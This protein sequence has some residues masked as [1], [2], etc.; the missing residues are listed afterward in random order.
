M[1]RSTIFLLGAL[2][3]AALPSIAAGAS[4]NDSAT[5]SGRVAD[6]FGASSDFSFEA[7]SG[8]AGEEAKGNLNFRNTQGYTENNGTAKVTCLLVSG[9]D[10]IMVGSW[11]GDDPDAWPFG[12]TF[13]YAVL[14][15]EDNGQP[16]GDTADRGIAFGVTAGTC[17]DWLAFANASALPLEQGNVVVRDAA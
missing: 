11:K 10:A 8:P 1:T 16:S 3:L 4:P 12:P 5:G 15:V 13:P 7:H 14:F 17:A 9:N 2:L 6:I